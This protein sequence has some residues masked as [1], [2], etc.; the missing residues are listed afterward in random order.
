MAKYS[1]WPTTDEGNV[2]GGRLKVEVRNR[3]SS[4]SNLSQT[5]QRDAALC[6]LLAGTSEVFNVKSFGAIGDG[7]TDD[8]VAIQSALDAV[9]AP[10]GVVLLPPGTYLIDALTSAVANTVMQGVG[11]GT[12]V[13]LATP[14]SLNAVGVSMT[15]SGCVVRDIHFNANSTSR[16]CVSL[17]ADDCQAHI[18]AEN[19][20]A[21]S[22]S[23]LSTSGIDITGN[24][25]TYSITGTAFANTGQSNESIPRLVT[26]QGTADNHYGLF[27]RGKTINCGL[28]TGASTVK[29]VCDVIDVE[30]ATDNGLYQLGGDLVVGSL[31]YNGGD[32]PAV[33]EG[34]CTVGVIRTRGLCSTVVNLQDAGDVHIG[35]IDII[36]DGTGGPASIVR[37]RSGNTASGNLQ[38]DAVR[39]EFTG[40]SFMAMTTGTV[41]KCSI[42]NLTIDWLYVAATAGVLTSWAKFDA[43]KQFDFRNWAVAIIDTNDTLTTE[44]FDMVGPTTNLAEKSFW[45]NVH[46]TI[47]DADRTTASSATLRGFNLALA[48]VETSG[49]RWQ[50]NIGPYARE[51]GYGNSGT[52]NV[53]PV[54]GTWRVGEILYDSTPATGG[55]VGWICTAAGTPGTWVMVGNVGPQSAAY[56]RAAT[57]VESRALLASA[58]ATATNNNNILA[59]LIADLQAAGLLT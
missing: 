18:T 16:T 54:G 40:N 27:V 14:A 29:G 17:S 52:S 20:T 30:D 5:G 1:S 31:I 9:T 58:S 34:D 26:V 47:Q 51:V 10:G 41:N 19:V 38:I 6:E 48:L 3:F 8:T 35:L 11:R 55:N 22:D 53:V 44:T 39:G 25:C 56:S 24:N 57:V 12:I 32:E 50:A 2:I 33:F 28:T 4:M 59:A 42:H 21:D 7:S 23:S 37:T 49:V 43:C 36:E 46:V 13:K 45:E 15:H